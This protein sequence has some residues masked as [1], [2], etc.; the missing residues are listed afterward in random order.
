MCITWAERQSQSDHYVVAVVEVVSIFPTIRCAARLASCCTA[1]R[2]QE[3]HETKSCMPKHPIR[4]CYA[5]PVN[6]HNQ[7]TT[8]L[9]R[10]FLLLGIAW[11]PCTAFLYELHLLPMH[12]TSP[13]VVTVT[14]ARPLHCFHSRY[15]PL[16]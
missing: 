15:N 5:N 8:S 1:D 16:D 9:V 7:Q 10:T 11:A 2:Q 13:E 14:R 3:R 4:F 6:V 12:R